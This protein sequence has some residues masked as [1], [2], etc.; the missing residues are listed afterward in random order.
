[1]TD[2]PR[3]RSEQPPGNP[4]D[5][6]LRELERITPDEILRRIH[7]SGFTEETAVLL[8]LVPLIQ[9]AWADGVVTPRE[10]ER[11]LR[12]AHLRGVDDRD[13]AFPTL[14]RWL[15]DQPADDFYHHALEAIRTLLMHQSPEQRSASRQD[16]LSICSSIASASR[17]IFRLR[18]IS[19]DEQAELELIAAELERDHEAA[20]RQVVEKWRRIQDS[21]DLASFL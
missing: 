19:D 7:A 1:V 16:L 17:G 11:V 18:R 13:P 14:E 5:E 15:T 3:T 21:S 6:R 4:E 8:H 2:K 20:V 10:R 9:V 12:A